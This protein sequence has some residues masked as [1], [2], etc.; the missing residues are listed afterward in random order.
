MTTKR[1]L[2]LVDDDQDV[3]EQLSLGLCAEGYEVVTAQGR[4]E[5]EEI[6]MLGQ[7]DLAIIDLMMEE[8][9]SGFV[10]CYE[11]KKLYPETPVIMLT[12]VTAT[13]GLDFHVR[14]K[15][16]RSWVKADALLDKPVRFEQLKEEVRRLL[17][18]RARQATAA[19]I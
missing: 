12:A 7:P 3:L 9:D 5:A 2:L 17:R 18:P 14:G 19:S 4:Q 8:M 6:L 16:A 10:L 13:T 1:R 11:V 15:E